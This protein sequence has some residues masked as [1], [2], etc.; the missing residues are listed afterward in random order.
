MFPCMVELGGEVVGEGVVIL[1]LEVFPFLLPF[2]A[3]P[4]GTGTSDRRVYQRLE[5]SKELSQQGTE[6][7]WMFTD[8]CAGLVRKVF[9]L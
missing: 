3:P 8:Q 9:H 5:V 7:L 6:V 4:G 2:Q 1:Y